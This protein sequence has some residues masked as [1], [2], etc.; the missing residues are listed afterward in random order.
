M[1]AKNRFFMP[2]DGYSITAAQRM[3]V[4]YGWV[5]VGVSFLTQFIA[6]GCLYYA[7]SIV[8]NLI[9]EELSGGSRTPILSLLLVMGVGGIVMAPIIGRIANRGYVRQL[10]FAGT[11]FTG[12]GLVA[13]AH[14]HSLWGLVLIFGTCFAFALN[15]MMGVTATTIIVSWFYSNRATAIGISNVGASLGGFVMAPIVS[16]IVA[17]YG[18]RETYE[19]LGF[20]TLCAAPVIWLVAI[21]SPEERNLPPYGIDAKKHASE[22]AVAAQAPLFSVPEALR[23]PNLWLIA[24]ASGIAFMCTTALVSHIVAF[25]TDAGF[26]PVDAAYFASLFALGGI[27]GKIGFGRMCDKVGEAPTFMIALTSSA[28][29]FVGLN[30]AS[31]YMPTAAL[32]TWI[33]LGLGG[34]LPLSSAILARAFGRRKFAGMFGLMWPIGQPAVLAGPVVAAWI[35][36]VHH[37]YRLAFWLFAAALVCAAGLIALT[38][39]PPRELQAEAPCREP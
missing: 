26:S 7:F 15:T 24:I 21:A 25:G 22:T 30:Y 27:I 19:I 14:T 20:C 1:Q 23:E 16:S 34:S 39:L 3:G 33:G 2:L 36:D 28:L 8:V 11:L 38:R 13:T 9:A 18:W 5:I 29:G 10:I 31:G 17:T 4:F 32:I 12:L 37:S 35:F 6:S